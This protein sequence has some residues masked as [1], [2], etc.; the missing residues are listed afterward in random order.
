MVTITAHQYR[1]KPMATKLS[2]A[3]HALLVAAALPNGA[4]GTDHVWLR[5]MRSLEK[6]GF[7]TLRNVREYYRADATDAGRAALGG[8]KTV[9]TPKEEA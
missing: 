2:P 1:E 8:K 3:Q 6:R 9:T 4:A 5:T 7:V